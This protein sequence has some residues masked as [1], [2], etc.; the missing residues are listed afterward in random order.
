[1]KR[2]TSALLSKRAIRLARA[3]NHWLIARFAVSAMWLLRKLPPDTALN[4]AAAAAKKIGPWFGRHRTALDNLRRAFP[5][6]SEQEIEALRTVLG[7]K[8]GT[9]QTELER[10]AAKATETVL[11]AERRR[12]LAGITHADALPRPPREAIDLEIRRQADER[13]HPSAAR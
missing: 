5:E 8:L 1:M 10:H 3:A 6:K 2:R 11:D 4:V 9:E 13:S 7:E 12:Y